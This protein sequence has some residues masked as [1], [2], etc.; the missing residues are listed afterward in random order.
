MCVPTS[1]FGGEVVR[2][3]N[4]VT[5]DLQCRAC[6]AAWLGLLFLPATTTN[7][8]SKDGCLATTT[9]HLFLGT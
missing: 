2:A 8:I 7:P 6:V 4:H 3:A 1:N 9:N 5:C